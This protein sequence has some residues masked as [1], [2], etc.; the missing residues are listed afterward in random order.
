MDSLIEIQDT[1]QLVT[2]TEAA[3]QVVRKLLDDK[4]IPNHHLRVFVAGGGCSGMQYG[5]AFEAAP[6]QGDTVVEARHGVKLLI[7][8]Q[9]T[10]YLMGA[11]VDYVDSIMG[12]G[13]R[14]EN[15]QAVSSC[16]CGHSFRTAASNSAQS[17]AG[18]CGCGD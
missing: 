13:F 18:G 3:S 11:Q 17:S 4:N 16:G 8:P 12:G 5:M 9:S 15:P 2:M 10:M 1:D 6:R 7:D 14:I